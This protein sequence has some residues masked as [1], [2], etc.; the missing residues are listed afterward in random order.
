[1]IHCGVCVRVCVLCVCSPGVAA[2]GNTAASPAWPHMAWWS[3][4]APPSCCSLRYLQSRRD[5]AW[6]MLSDIK[7]FSAARRGNTSHVP[8][9]HLKSDCQSLSSCVNNYPYRWIPVSWQQQTTYMLSQELKTEVII[10]ITIKTTGGFII[11]ISYKLYA[12]VLE[13]K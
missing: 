1:M 8:F 12:E 6:T 4:P 5:A 11:A 10:L 13:L 7:L 9:K 3:I 2:A